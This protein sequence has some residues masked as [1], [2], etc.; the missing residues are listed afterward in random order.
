MKSAMRILVVD[1]SKV[2][3]S[4]LRKILREIGHEDVVEASDG[5]EALDKVQASSFDLVITDWNM[6]NLDGL[7]LVRELQKGLSNVPVLMVSSESY[8][9]RIV[10]VMR[11]GAEGYIRKPFTAETLN[12]KITEVRKKRELSAQAA[13]AASL[14]GRLEEIGFPELIQ[15]LTGCRRNGRVVI[16]SGGKSG[17]IDLREG[18]ARAAEWGNLSGDEA[19]Y[20]IAEQ[21]AGTFRFQ[22]AQGSVQ[23]NI[24]LPTMSLLIEA[25]RKRDEKA[26]AV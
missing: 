16:E 1:D 10:D 20:A 5:V 2:A 13:T 18:E 17:T 22:P 6:P 24:T 4:V 19:V 9:N 15:F 8:F 14:A 21:D 11:A 23:R 12:Q 7:G 3:R 26:S 25:L